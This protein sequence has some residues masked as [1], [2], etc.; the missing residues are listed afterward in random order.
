MPEGVVVPLEAADIDD[1][2]AAPADALLDRQVALD[3]LHEPV[4]VQQ[5][6]LRIAVR[7]LGQVGDDLLEVAGDVADGD[8]LFG[9]LPLQAL[10]LDGEPLGKGPNC[11]VLRLFDQLALPGDHRFDRLQ[12][13]GRT[14]AVE[15][16]AVHDEL[17]QVGG[18]YE[19]SLYQGSLEL[20]YRTLT[21][22]VAMATP[23]YSRGVPPTVQMRR[24]SL[25][26]P[27]FGAQLSNPTNP[28]SLLRHC[29]ALRR[30]K[31]HD[32]GPDAVV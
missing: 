23:S 26:R 13:L 8:L 24:I 18:L 6:G 9:K 21:R 20:R 7:L 28:R 29:R 2:D 22:A 15:T 31:R 11:L 14:G 4:E 19:G 5:L 30:R 17:A 3:P 27:V 32:A 16:Q 25:D 12:E 10:H 1:A